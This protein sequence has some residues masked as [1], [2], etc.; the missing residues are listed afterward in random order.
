MYDSMVEPCILT[1]GNIWYHV[2]KKSSRPPTI[3]KH[4]YISPK[5]PKSLHLEKIKSLSKNQKNL[6]KITKYYVISSK[7][8]K[9]DLHFTK[10]QGAKTLHLK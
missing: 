2:L 5:K 7:N 8:K 1:R 9:W 3:V 4:A 10:S 6:K